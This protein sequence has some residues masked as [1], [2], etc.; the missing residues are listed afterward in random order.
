MWPDQKFPPLEPFEHVEHGKGADPS[1]A[2]LL[3][4][5]TSIT[6]MTPSIGSEVLGLQLSR[7]SNIQKDQ[8]ALLIA[9]RKLVVFRDQDFAELAIQEAVDFA[10]YFGRPYSTHVLF[11]QSS[12]MNVL[13]AM[14]CSTF[15]VLSFEPLNSAIATPH[16]HE[17]NRQLTLAVHLTSGCPEGYPEIHLVHRGAGDKGAKNFM[18]NRINTIGW[19]CDS[20]FE[21][22]CPGITMLYVLGHPATGGDT[23]FVDQ[24]Q[25]YNNLSSEFQKR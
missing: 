19:H 20:S 6:D 15:I 14:W 9:Q 13:Q 5:G 25:A 23:L 3:C 21:E 4:E 12:K 10:A 7:L 22:Q 8:L 1:L 24:V 16:S 17:I 2:D 18:S 11:I